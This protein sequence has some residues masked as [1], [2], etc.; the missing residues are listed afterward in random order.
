MIKRKDYIKVL[1][2][3]VQERVEEKSQNKQDDEQE[4]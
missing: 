1:N 3:T 2:N 4:R